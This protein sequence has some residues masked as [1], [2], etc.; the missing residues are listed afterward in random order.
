MAEVGGQ[1]RTAVLRRDLGDG[2]SELAKALGDLGRAAAA[3]L[4]DRTAAQG[5]PPGTAPGQVQP[6]DGLTQLFGGRVEQTPHLQHRGGRA[7]R[8][9]EHRQVLVLDIAEIG[10][11][12]LAEAVDQGALGA[13]L[14]GGIGP[15]GARL[16]VGGGAVLLE[17]D[18]Q[19]HRPDAAQ[20]RMAHPRNRL[21]GG[22]PL[23]QVHAEEGAL[24]P[25]QRVRAQR[26]NAVAADIALDLDRPE[27]EDR[28]SHRPAHG[29]PRRRAEQH[30]EQQRRHRIHQADV[31]RQR[32]G[33][34]V[35]CRSSLACESSHRHSC[36]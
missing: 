13:G 24:E 30:G 23:L 26:G 7:R 6:V 28:Q 25:R 27:I 32:G 34:S 16:P 9:G 15:I 19:P 3:Q 33:G 31:G 10:L 1:Q 35:H 5:R 22:A 2:A 36:G 8:A 11:E 21:E 4:D 12:H 14:G 29:C 17:P 18:P 20:L